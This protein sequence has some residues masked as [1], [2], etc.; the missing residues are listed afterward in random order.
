MPSFSNWWTTGSHPSIQPFAVAMDLN[1][2][3]YYLPFGVFAFLSINPIWLW[4]NRRNCAAD[5]DSSSIINFMPCFVCNHNS[6]ELLPLK[7]LS[8][9]IFL[10]FSSFATKWQLY[11]LKWNQRWQQ[12]NQKNANK[13]NIAGPGASSLRVQC[14]ASS[15][16]L[17][18]IF[19][20]VPG[21]CVIHKWIFDWRLF[22]FDFGESRIR[23]TTKS[24]F[25]LYC[26][27]VVVFLWQV[28]TTIVVVGA[29]DSVALDFFYVV[30][31]LFDGSIFF[32][33]KGGV[34]LVFGRNSR[35]MQNWNL[36]ENCM[37]LRTK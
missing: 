31:A 12:Q 17:L 28:N 32:F 11:G 36:S 30:V 35:K 4:R 3:H 24:I 10:L 26:T 25:A 1:C 13:K 33:C 22:D 14:G 27:W 15:T 9:L 19:L 6:L 2:L 5:D 37:S 29:G 21:F 20:F 23:S 18:Y 34:C 7:K 8:K 16:S